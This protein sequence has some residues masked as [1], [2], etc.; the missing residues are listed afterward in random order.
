V[1]I[2]SDKRNTESPTLGPRD[3]LYCTFKERF[4]QVR[5]RFVTVLRSDRFVRPEQL[6]TRS[7]IEL[8]AGITRN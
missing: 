5:D 8:M 2:T 6:N 3:R 1:K 4:V 7:V